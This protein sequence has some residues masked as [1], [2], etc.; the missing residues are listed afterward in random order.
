MRLELEEEIREQM[1]ANQEKLAVVTDAGS[2]W[3]TKVSHARFSH[4]KNFV[5][6]LFYFIVSCCLLLDPPQK[7]F[8]LV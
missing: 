7:F 3:Q 6:V 4:N 1:R 5:C 2:S 8:T